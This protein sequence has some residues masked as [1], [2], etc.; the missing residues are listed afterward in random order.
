MA[1]TVSDHTFSVFIKLTVLQVQCLG[2]RPGILEA[3]Q[4][5]FL[6]TAS[7]RA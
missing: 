6:S 2:L 1:A 5:C 4:S 7:T 3:L